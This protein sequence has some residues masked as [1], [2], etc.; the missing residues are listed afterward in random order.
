MN[1]EPAHGS[2]PAEDVALWHHVMPPWVPVLVVDTQRRSAG[3]C[4]TWGNDLRGK[5]KKEGQRSGTR[6]AVGDEYLEW[7]PCVASTTTGETKPGLMR[8]DRWLATWHLWR[9]QLHFG[10]KVAQRSHTA[11]NQT[12]SP[13]QV[14]NVGRGYWPHEKSGIL[15]VCLFRCQQRRTVL[16]SKPLFILLLLFVFFFSFTLDVTPTSWSAKQNSRWTALTG[17]V[18]KSPVSTFLLQPIPCC[19]AT[20]LRKVGQVLPSAVTK[21]LQTMWHQTKY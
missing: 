16:K 21:C 17:E 3:T 14:K 10:R 6:H 8:P 1:Y 20:S 4:F 2:V 12:S 7:A 5:V 15:F 9:H 11:A 18:L 13:T 19:F